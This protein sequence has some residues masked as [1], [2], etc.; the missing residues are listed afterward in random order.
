MKTIFLLVLTTAFA[1]TVETEPVKVIRAYDGDTITVAG[2]V[3]GIEYPVKVRLLHVDT[4]EIRSNSHGEAME[5]GMAA[6]DLVRSLVLGD[7]VKVR[8]WSKGDKLNTDRY[9]RVLAVVMLE[10]GKSVQEHLVAAGLSPYW[11]KYGDAY[12]TLHDA[13]IDAQTQ[14]K[15]DTKGLWGSNRKWIQDKSNE[16]TAPK[17]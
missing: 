14:A 8:L 15:I 6:R 2:K 5:E 16:R 3:G 7:D 10:D 1:Y 13:L 4:P 17:E 11:R 9:G 12:G